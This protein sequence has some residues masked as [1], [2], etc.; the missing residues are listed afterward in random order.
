MNIDYIETSAKDGTNVEKV[1]YD[2]VRAIRKDRK[3]R[4]VPTKP[5]RRFW[6]SIL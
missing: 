3:V 1:F 5:K 2:L 4:K 6:C